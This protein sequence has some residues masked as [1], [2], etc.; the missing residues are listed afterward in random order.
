VFGDIPA[1][2]LDWR[3]RERQAQEMLASLRVGLLLLLCSVVALS[4][5]ACGGAHHGKSPIRA[6]PPDRAAAKTTRARETVP[7]K[8][9]AGETSTRTASP[10]AT[11]SDS[12]LPADVVARVGRNSIAVQTLEH[13]IEVQAVVQYQ[14]RPTRPVPRGV[15]PKPPDYRDCI[16]YLAAIAKARKTR[17]EPAA[18]QLDHQCAQKHETLLRSMLEMLIDHFWVNEEAARA[19]VA[20][21]AREI[22]QALRRRF[23]T[24]VELHRFLALTR[25]RASDERL[26]LK[27][28]L[29]LG[30]WQHASLPVYARLRR[31]KPPETA[32]MA[33][34]VDVELGKLS[35]SM[36]RR[37]TPRTHCRAGYVVALCAEYRGTSLD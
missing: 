33:D 28:V 3:F 11:V 14:S 35:E 12:R 29:L 34:E 19:G 4:L 27:N 13:W 6:M 30:K 15:V 10:S 21:A 8:S 5:S 2:S 25:L 36:K 7:D 24:E 17:P 23:P 37:W 20:V 1:A 16:A 9:A 31:S 18:A 22:N 26:L 32:Q